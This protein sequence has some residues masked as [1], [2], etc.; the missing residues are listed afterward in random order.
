MKTV[1]IAPRKYTQGRGVMAEIGSTLKPLG[2][3]PVVL[4]DA[5]VRDIVGQTVR[6]SIAAAGL[7]LVEV[8]FGGE[9]TK[10]QA[11]RLVQIIGDSGG[12]VSIGIG[13]G[14]VLDVAKAAAVEAGV[15][16]VT[17]PTIASTDSP[18]SAATVWYEESGDFC[19]FECWPFNPDVVLVDTQ[20]IANGPARAFCAGMGDAMATWVE[21]EAAIKTWAPNLA[22]AQPTMV[23]IAIARLCY[24]TLMEFGV[25]ARRAVEAH[26]V[27]P[28]VEKVV[29][30]NTLMS[31][32]G[33]E[34]GGLAT[35]HMVANLLSNQPEC[36]GLMH[37]EKVSFGIVSQLCLDVETDVEEMCNIVDFLIAVGLP[38]T[39]A[40]LN[41]SDAPRERLVQIA[42][43]CAGEGSL[44]GNHNFPVTGADV[45]DAMLAADL[46]GQHRKEL[47]E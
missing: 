31:G 34:S 46:L 33:F 1:L 6:D 36:K 29:E 42:D 4:W 22:G 27:T 12:D 10:Q 45:V 40:E 25:E 8:E 47:F 32:L 20:V 15:K 5:V 30:A 19:G 2:R 44:C 28:A 43:V 18:T 13:G 9:A 41:L 3:K 38:V 37:G 16:L 35:A 21:T 14:K 7:E 17:C 26:L 24:E 39:L 11:E 23:A